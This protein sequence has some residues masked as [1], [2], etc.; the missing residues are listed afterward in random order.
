MSSSDAA[1]RSARHFPSS[2][3]ISAITATLLLTAMLVIGS[4]AGGCQSESA[5]MDPT[6]SSL[7][8]PSAVETSVSSGAMTFPPGQAV[9]LFDGQQLGL[10]EGAGYSATFFFSFI[11]AI[12]CSP[13]R[14]CSF[15][16]S[17]ASVS[18]SRR[19]S[20]SARRARA[21]S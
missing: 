4:F 20:M 12:T 8:P 7:E 1:Q 5:A 14:S 11:E 9:S 2:R 13:Q 16:S 6:D 18:S 21:I 15:K 3:V 10:W 19:L 17:M